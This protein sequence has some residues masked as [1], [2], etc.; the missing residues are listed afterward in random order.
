MKSMEMTDRI[1]DR[2]EEICDDEDFLTGV[3]SVLKND[4]ECEHLLRLIDEYDVQI[5]DNVLIIAVLI[6]EAGDKAQR[7][8]DYLKDI[9]NEIEDAILDE[10]DKD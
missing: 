4:Y 9:D 8:G 1:L 6:G 3:L 7:I 5:P 10:D 2:L